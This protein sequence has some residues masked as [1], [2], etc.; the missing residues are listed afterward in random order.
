M[1]N[2]Q[3]IMHT[4]VSNRFVKTHLAVLD[5]P[6]PPLNDQAE[7]VRVVRLVSKFQGKVLHTASSFD[8][9]QLPCAC[10]R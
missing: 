10:V 1:H 9:P 7:P 4:N 6:L 3:G 2:K 8:G 5:S